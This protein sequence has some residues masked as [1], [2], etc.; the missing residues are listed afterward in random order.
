MADHQQPATGR[1]ARKIFS[2]PAARLG[3]A[4]LAL[5]ALILLSGC[6]DV[7]KQAVITTEAADPIPY[8]GNQFVDSDGDT[9]TWSQ[10]GGG[11]TYRYRETSK[12]GHTTN[13]ELRVMNIRDNIYAV[14]LKSD[15]EDSYE[16]E[17]FSITSSNITE[18]EISTDDD[19]LAN[20]IAHRSGLE[21]GSVESNGDTAG[22]DNSKD[23][24][25][26][27]EL[28][29]TPEQILGFLRGLKEVRFANASN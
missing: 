16:V 23:V 2:T 1:T 22:V 20:S 7:G 21:N 4:G 3:L 25:T 9:Y 12:S 5:T 27:N 26:A 8:S 17:L 29:G 24:L 11:T 19:A 14:Q 6:W 18:V 15:S 10:S 13:G 28:Y